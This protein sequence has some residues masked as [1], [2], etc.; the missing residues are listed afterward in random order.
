MTT[1][2]E[3][4]SDK[5]KARAVAF[6]DWLTGF[7]TRIVEFGCAMRLGQLATAVISYDAAGKSV[8]PFLKNALLAFDSSSIVM[9]SILSILCVFQLIALAHGTF[10]KRS[11]GAEIYN[12]RCVVSA[13][14]AI[15]CGFIV[16]TMLGLGQ[17]FAVIWSY[18]IAVA[19]NGFDA[20][21][22]WSKH[23]D[24]KELQKG[25]A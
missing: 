25:V 3:T 13:M 8:A 15:V 11:N 22:L 21:V 24:S 10:P 17:P 20:I 7:D 4:A 5:G 2:Y 1:F 19:L 23:E 12:F 6:F 16:L 18:T 14:S 9:L